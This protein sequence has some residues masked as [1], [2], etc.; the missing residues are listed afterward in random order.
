MAPRVET[1]ELQNGSITRFS[2]DLN[3]PDE[4]NTELF[5]RLAKE[6]NCTVSVS[7]LKYI[8]IEGRMWVFSNNESH[9]GLWT[10]LK[11]KGEV[12]R[13]QSAGC[14]EVRHYEILPRRILD[15]WS[16][17]LDPDLLKSDSNRY[18]LGPLKEKLGN[19]F[20]I[21]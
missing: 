6:V 11:N 7:I 10:D 9:Y 4:F 12:G 21:E 20:M 5:D 1:P 18:K 14:I 19:F 13:L 8:V 17:S 2:V 16:S 15:D 3:S